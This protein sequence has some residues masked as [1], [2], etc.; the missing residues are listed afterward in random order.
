MDERDK[1]SQFKILLW[2]LAVL[3]SVNL[4]VVGYVALSF[5]SLERRVTT[6]E[7]SRWTARDGATLFEKIADINEHLAGLPK[8]YSPLWLQEAVKDNKR[9]IERL[10]GVR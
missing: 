8:E 1:D 9:R 7:A 5:F 6:I 10:E 3:V 4:S 2:L